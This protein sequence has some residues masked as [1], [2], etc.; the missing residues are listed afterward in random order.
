MFSHFQEFK[1]EVDK[2][3]GQHEYFLMHS[4]HTF[5]KKESDGNLLADT[6]LNKME[7]PNVGTNIYSRW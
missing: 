6:H 3:T 4:Q 7:L 5:G 2:A 1:N